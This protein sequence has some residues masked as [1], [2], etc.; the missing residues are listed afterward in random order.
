MQK[1]RCEPASMNHCCYDHPLK[2]MRQRQEGH[3]DI[4]R[5]ETMNLMHL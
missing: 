3:I 5:S 4:I 2:D 1:L